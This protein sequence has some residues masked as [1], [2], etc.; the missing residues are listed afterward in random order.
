MAGIHARMSAGIVRRTSDLRKVSV[1][2]WA[3]QHTG[4][5]EVRDIREVATL[6]AVI[7]HVNNKN[8]AGAIDI[9]AQRVLAI[10]AAK[11]KGGSWDKAEIL[12]LLPGHNVPLAAGGMMALGT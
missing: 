9:L 12:E 7:D 1:Q 4:L 5:S 2:Q 11:R 6:A 3:Q 8:L 10:Q